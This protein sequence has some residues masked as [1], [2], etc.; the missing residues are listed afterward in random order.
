LRRLFRH[1][2]PRS[3]LHLSYIYYRLYN[4]LD[5]RGFIGRYPR[6]YAHFDM[7]EVMNGE[8]LRGM[9]LRCLGAARECT[10]TAAK[11]KFYDIAEELLRKANEIEGLLTPVAIRDPAPLSR[12][13]G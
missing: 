5:T 3:I 10:E 7:A 11:S 2:Y 9:A 1:H 4:L 13:R 6:S 12:N 8:F